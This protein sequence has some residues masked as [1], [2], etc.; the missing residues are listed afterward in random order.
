MKLQLLHLM[1]LEVPQKYHHYHQ[2]FQQMLE[3]NLMMPL[4][5]LLPH[6]EVIELKSYI[7]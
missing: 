2:Q 6:Q 3:D 1:V 4:L 5:Y 7:H